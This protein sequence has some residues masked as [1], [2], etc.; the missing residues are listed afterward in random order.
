M[1]PKNVISA[2]GAGYDATCGELLWLLGRI[3]TMAKD[4]EMRSRQESYFR[5][6]WEVSSGDI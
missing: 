6:E 1:P 5:L 3:L 2:K 4:R